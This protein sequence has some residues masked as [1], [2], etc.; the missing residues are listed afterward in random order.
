MRELPA[1]KG[2]VDLTFLPRPQHAE[3]PALVIELKWDQTAE[4]AICQIKDKQY[5]GALKDYAGEVLLVG[6][7]YDR[8]TRQHTAVIEKIQP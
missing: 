2:F 4:I 3:K 6:I 5:A 1:G 8:R 7:S